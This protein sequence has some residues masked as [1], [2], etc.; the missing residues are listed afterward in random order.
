MIHLP[1]SHSHYSTTSLQ[2]LG[3][4]YDSFKEKK[5]TIG[6]GKKWMMFWELFFLWPCICGSEYAETYMNNGRLDDIF[7]GTAAKSFRDFVKHMGHTESTYPYHDTGNVVLKFWKGPNFKNREGGNNLPKN[8]HP[9]DKKNKKTKKIEDNQEKILLGKTEE[10]GAEVD[11]NEEDMKKA[12]DGNDADVEE[13]M[14]TEGNVAVGVGVN[15]D[16]EENNATGILV[17]ENVEENNASG[18]LVG[19]NNDEKISEGEANNS[20]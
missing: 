4:I 13:G 12:N 16:V 1:F 19:K 11:K 3:G 14:E 7:K 20:C 9:W 8:T 18:G 17:D 2:C 10:V 6:D 5:D 15:N